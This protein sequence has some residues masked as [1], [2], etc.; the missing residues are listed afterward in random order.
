LPDTSKQDLLL[1]DIAIILSQVTTLANK[2]KDLNHQTSEFEAEI[3]ELKKEKTGLIQKISMLETE[4]ENIKK[5]NHTEIFN[6][7]DEE[8]REDLKSKITNLISKID[9]HISS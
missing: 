9:L 2:Y 5:Q 8:E 4:I 3:N 6:S 1:K 7:L